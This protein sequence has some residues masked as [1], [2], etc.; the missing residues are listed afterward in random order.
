MFKYNSYINEKIEKKNLQSYLLKVFAKMSLGLL[1]TSIVSSI[2]GFLLPNMAI[3][4]LSNPFLMIFI[5]IIQ[6]VIIYMMQKQIAQEKINNLNMLYYSF[7]FLNGI[8]LTYI[9]FIFRV[10]EILLAFFS[11]SLFFAVMCIYGYITKNDL[12]NWSSVL[13]G[14]IICITILSVFMM[15]LNLIFNYQ[16]IFISFLISLVTII[17]M[18]LYTA[19]DMQNLINIYKNNNINSNMKNILSTVGAFNFYLNFVIIFQH[20]LRIISFIKN[21]KK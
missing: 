6:Y 15:I 10:E 7:T 3:I 21:D 13:K 9:F 5:G 17:V 2:I 20:L 8:L 18:S 14:S 12:S 19:Y 16:N 1:I 11:T 4:F